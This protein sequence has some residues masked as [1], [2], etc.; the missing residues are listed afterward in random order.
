MD[1]GCFL[2]P[3]RIVIDNL[4]SLLDDFV[5]NGMKVSKDR[6]Y[7]PPNEGGLGLIHLGTFLIAQKCSWV[8]RLHANTIDNWRLRFRLACPA[9]DVT[10]VRSIDFDRRSTPIL[11]EVASAFETFVGCFGKIGNNLSVVPIFLNPSIVRSLTDRRLLDIA[12]FGKQ[13]YES[14]KDAIRKLTINECMI[15]SR[16][17][18]IDEF[19][20]M[21]L[22]FSIKTW[23]GLRSAIIL[24]KK[25]LTRV[26]TRR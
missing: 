11:F 7:L 8:Q 5:V 22:P 19:N 21:N 13:F 2:T 26:I 9:F 16:F 15:E 4:Q 14:H 23:M 10:L 20:D 18:N 24:A 1:L 6:Y 12:F 17:K 3:S 25:K